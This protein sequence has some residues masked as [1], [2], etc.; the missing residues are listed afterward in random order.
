MIP[1][2][3]GQATK[4]VS[5]YR[6]QFR[7]YVDIM[8]VIQ[9]ENNEAKPTRILYRANLSHDRLTKYL[10]ELKNLGVIQ[11]NGIDDKTYS[12]TQKGVEFVNNFRKVDSFA[13]A[14][15]FTI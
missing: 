4:A 8:H 10:D 15:G 2:E 13:S 11:E 12:L 9:H 6:S 1:S 14:F 3:Q 5:K 7:I